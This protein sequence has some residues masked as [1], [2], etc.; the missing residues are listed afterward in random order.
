M[1]SRKSWF[2]AKYIWQYGIGENRQRNLRNKIESPEVDTILMVNLSLTNEQR[3]YKGEKR[4]ITVLEQLDIHMQKRKKERKE[5]RS[6]HYVSR[7]IK[8]NCRQMWNTKL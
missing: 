2:K 6:R 1:T 7:K 3:W 4:I 8:I 5:S